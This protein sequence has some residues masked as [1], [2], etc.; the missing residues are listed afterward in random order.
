MYNVLQSLP[1][2][3]Y[4]KLLNTDLFSFIYAWTVQVK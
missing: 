4:V 3:F 2:L 1:V